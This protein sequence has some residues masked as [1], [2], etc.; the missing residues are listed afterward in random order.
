MPS[1]GRSMEPPRRAGRHVGRLLRV[2]SLPPLGWPW[3]PAHGSSCFGRCTNGLHRLLLHGA[4]SSATSLRRSS[5][6]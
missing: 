2:P 4:R 5:A 3:H 1:L 6:P